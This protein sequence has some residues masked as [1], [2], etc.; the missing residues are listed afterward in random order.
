MSK[1]Q[2]LWSHGASLP[3]FQLR[4]DTEEEEMPLLDLV[5]PLGLPVAPNA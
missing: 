1:Y 4:A 3:Q 5:N 2:F